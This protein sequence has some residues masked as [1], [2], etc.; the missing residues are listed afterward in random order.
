MH[1][2]A[3]A[4]D[5]HLFPDGSMFLH[6]AILLVMI[7]VLNRTLFRPI[8]RVI[9]AREKSMGGH[10]SEAD[11]ILKKV[12]GKES[13]Y[14]KETLDA[15]SQGYALIEGEQKQAIAER[16]KKIGEAKTEAAG[17]FESG[18]AE[19]EKQVADARDVIAAEADKAADKIASNILQS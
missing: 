5:I 12:E 10:S 13:R 16:E 14:S 15:R 7:W 18:K 19:I 6:I 17:R 8:N 4:G 3:F 1:L 9:E 2:L 11:E